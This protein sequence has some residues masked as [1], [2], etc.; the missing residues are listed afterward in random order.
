MPTKVIVARNTRMTP[1]DL[2][3]SI[4]ELQKLVLQARCEKEEL[5]N[6]V[7]QAKREMI[8]AKQQ[9]I[10]T[11]RVA[12]QIAITQSEEQASRAAAQRASVSGPGISTP[13]ARYSAA[14]CHQRSVGRL[15]AKKG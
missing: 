6:E 2:P 10:E 7:D 15:K 3:T 9:T 5:R 12:K 14:A 4:E 11:A 1:K 8:I 13:F